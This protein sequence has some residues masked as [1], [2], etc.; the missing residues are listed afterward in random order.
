MAPPFHQSHDETSPPSKHRPSALWHTSLLPS[1]FFIKRGDFF[2]FKWSNSGLLL[3]CPFS[4]LLEPHQPWM[5][6]REGRKLRL[7]L[8]LSL[9]PL[10][11][12]C[13]AT[14]G[15]DSWEESHGSVVKLT[16][17]SDRLC[18]SFTV[19]LCCSF[20]P[21]NSPS[22]QNHVFEWVRIVWSW[23]GTR[24]DWR[25]EVWELQMQKDPSESSWKSPQEAKLGN[26]RITIKYLGRVQKWFCIQNDI[27]GSDETKASSF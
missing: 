27:F 10:F 13:C 25:E 23:R 12:G 17:N 14:G 24:E 5:G 9:I 22:Y 6:S 26:R 15:T 8:F 2:F 16:G 21:F 1:S 3:K 19:S 7:H 11:P 20:S 18:F 4:F